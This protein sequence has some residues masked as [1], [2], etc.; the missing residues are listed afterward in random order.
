MPCEMKFVYSKE[1][2]CFEFVAFSLISMT[3]KW[4][5]ILLFFFF[6]VVVD[7]VAVILLTHHIPFSYWWLEPYTI[8]RMPKSISI[9]FIISIYS[10]QH[11]NSFSHKSVTL[12]YVF[13]S[14]F[15]CC[16]YDDRLYLWILVGVWITII[17]HFS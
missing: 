16:L 6:V 17:H 2:L 5:E 8:L 12:E 15:L 7:K 3:T 10:K 14:S 13:F 1:F 11:W 4:M 9:Q